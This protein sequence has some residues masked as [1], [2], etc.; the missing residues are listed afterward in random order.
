MLSKKRSVIVV[1]SGV[2]GLTCALSLIEK[3]LR[4]TLITKSQTS[5]SATWYAQGGVASAMFSDDSVDSH[6]Q[7]TLNAGAQLCD[8]SAVQVLVENGPEALAKLISRGAHFD[9]LADGSFA[10]TREGGHSNSRIIHAGGDATGE[11]IERSLIKATS[12][13]AM[14]N[15]EIMDYRMVTRLLVSRGRIAGVECIDALGSTLEIEASDVVLATGGAGQLFSVTTNPILSTGDGIAAALRAGVLC[16]DLEF[17][18]FHPTALHVDN[19]PRPLISEALR[20]EGAVLR[21]EAG[22]LFMQGKHELGDLAPRDVVSREIAKVLRNQKLDYVF[23]DATQIENFSQRFP[24]IYLSCEQAGIN[25]T[26]DFLPVSPAAHYYCGGVATDLHGATSLPGLWAAGEVSCNGIHGA[27]RLA[28][29]SLLDGLVFGEQVAISISNGVESVSPSGL[30]SEID[31]LKKFSLELNEVDGGGS[32]FEHYCEPTNAVEIRKDLQHVMNSGAGVVR[33]QIGLKNAQVELEDIEVK[34]LEN[35]VKSGDNLDFSS[36]EL[37]HLLSVGTAM[38]QSALARNES[39][40]C[41]TREDHQLSLD[42]QLG[43]YFTSFSGQNIHFIPI[44]QTK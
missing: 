23:L 7:D 11:E 9:K 4:V 29:N 13:I 41:H 19:M 12:D 26:K 22:N 37:S 34:V 28:S 6:L 36:L 35:E 20:G 8:R 10:R 32:T 43:H 33:N 18:Q 2:A 5:D 40:G 30:F 1:G 21:D 15:L 44:K 38:V 14:E 39:R 24:T 42:S 27:N 25:P 16:T 31:D 3:N 17:M